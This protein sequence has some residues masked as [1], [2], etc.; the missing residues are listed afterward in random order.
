[1]HARS[2]GLGKGS[3]FTVRLPEARSGTGTHSPASS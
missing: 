1:V 2:E 3:E